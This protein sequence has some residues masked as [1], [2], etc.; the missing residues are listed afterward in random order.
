M[1][2]A[3]AC[4]KS[5][6]DLR[7]KPACYSSTVN[8]RLASRDSS[9]PR[10]PKQL[11]EGSNGEGLAP[12]R[13]FVQRAPQQ[14]RLAASRVASVHVLAFVTDVHKLIARH[15]QVARQRQEARG[16]R[17]AVADDGGRDDPLV[18]NRQARLQEIRKNQASRHSV[19]H[20]GQNTSRNAEPTQLGQYVRRLGKRP[21]ALPEV[22]EEGGDASVQEFERDAPALEELPKDVLCGKLAV[23]WSRGAP[24][25][26]SQEHAGSRSQ[27]LR[28]QLAPTRARHR[29][30]RRRV[31]ALPVE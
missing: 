18:G 29:R 20:V 25:V 6:R 1:F 24:R 13:S 23:I 26:V 11:F 27:P 9:E 8:D 30:E 19:R 4:A 17:L 16:M 31:L 5:H 2:D 15:A 14:N 7:T 28:R 22:A 3:S 21:K 10:Q 12:R